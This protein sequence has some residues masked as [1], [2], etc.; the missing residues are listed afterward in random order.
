MSDE[1]LRDEVMTLLIAGHETTAI[2]LSW[3]WY[4]LARNSEAEKNLWSEL[5][6]V[7]KGRSPKVED[8][9]ALSY[10]ECVIKE[11]MRLYP[12]VWAVVRTVL[13]DFELGGYR[14][15]AGATI[16]VS[17]W[18]THRDP[19]YFDEPEEFKPDR[20]LDRKYADAKFVYFPFGAGPRAC[21]GASFAIMETVLVLATIAQ[22]YQI[23]VPPEVTIQPV[24][25]FTLRPQ[26]GINVV[27]A[28][29]V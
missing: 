22:R 28:R 17:Q 25:T 3:V 26:N 10:A 16:I 19:R 15:P 13:N 1:Q 21:I 27:L 14:V 23:R 20:W 4:L 2:S 24:P 5:R 8:L 29:R 12:P 7:L 18:V 9:P 6:D 11:A